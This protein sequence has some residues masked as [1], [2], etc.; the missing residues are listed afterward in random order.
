MDVLAVASEVGRAVA[1]L[2]AEEGETAL[3]QVN[4]FWVIVSALNFIV[5]FVLI[6]T[7]AFKPVSKMLDDRRDRIEQGL[8]D[9]EQ[10]RRDRENAEAERVATLAEARKEANE[11]LTRAQKVAQ[12]TR[13]ADIAA[14]REEL[15]RMRERAAERHRGGEAAGHRRAP[16]RGRRPGPG[17]RQ[18]RR[19]RVADRRSPAPARRGVPRASP[20]TGTRRTDGPPRTAPRA[21]TRRRRSR[22]PCATGRSRRWRAE[23]DLAAGLVGDERALHVLANPSIPV[24]QRASGTR[25]DARRPRLETRHEPHPADAPARPDRGPAARRRGVPSSRRRRARASPTPPP[26]PQPR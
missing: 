9:A 7:F 8:K 22:S 21:A 2:T 24:E 15:E 4:L 23:L 3:F 20:T 13:D 5:F 16:R 12:E 26:R 18:S 1:Q 10:A 6:W 14:T 19:G 11:I 25:R 17:R